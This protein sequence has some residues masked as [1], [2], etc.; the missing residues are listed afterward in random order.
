VNVARARLAAWMFALAAV[1]GVLIAVDAASPLARMLGVIAA[2]FVGL[3]LVVA[4]EW[5]L[6]GGEMSPARWLLFTVGWIGMRPDAFAARR[7]AE[8]GVSERDRR[9]KATRG[10]APASERRLDVWPGV[11]ALALGAVLLVV[12]RRLV[13]RAPMLAAVLAL[14]AFSLL[15][16]FGVL[17]LVALFWRSRGFDV[18]PPFDAPLRAT[19]LA[20]FWS[21]R[22]NRAF[23][24]MAALVVY[25]PIAAQSSDVARLAAFGFSGLLHELAISVPV[26]GGYGGPMAY[27]VFHGLL[28]SVERRLH[29]RGLFRSSRA[30][31]L[32]TFAG[33][34]LPLPLLFHAPFLRGVILPLLR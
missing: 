19:T 34:V 3:K 10:F 17:R 16:H 20:E 25:R 5:R 32:W 7:G 8:R 30:A 11:R 29:A 9:Q 22:W 33:I 4:V 15:V 21:R 23:S 31:R 24:E 14:P 28:A 27:F 6:A 1:A 18:A 2:L 26:R 12:A 13:P